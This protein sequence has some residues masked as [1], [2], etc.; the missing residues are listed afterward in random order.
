MKKYIRVPAAFAMLIAIGT[1]L[2]VSGYAQPLGAGSK[3]G[4][5]SWRRVG[6]G[7]G[8]AMFY[9]AV[10]PHNPN[11]AFVSC[12]MGG[13]YATY[14]GG[15]SWRMFNLRSPVHYYVFDP[16]DS[17]VVYANSVALFKSNDRGLSWSVLYPSPA[18]IKAIVSRGDHAE[19]EVVTRDSSRRNV[20]AMAV[21]P[22]DSRKLYAAISIDRSVAFY[23]SENSGS[24]WVREHDLSDGAMDIFVVPS[25]PG[26]NRTILVTGHNSITTKEDG[27]WTVNKGPKGVES[28]TR[29]SGGFDARQNKFIIYAISG[30]SYFNPGGDSSGIFFS[31]DGGQNWE[32]RKGG[33]RKL[34]SAGE[35]EWRTV[36][37]S[38]LHPAIVYVSYNGLRVGG[39]TS[40]IGVAV[41]RDFGQSWTLAWQDRLAPKNNLVSPNMKT[42]WIDDRFGP[43]W[44]ENPFSIGVAPGDPN[45]CYATDFGRTIKTTN[46]GNTWEQVYTTRKTGGGWM[47]TGLEVT[48]GYS[49]VFDPF[50]QQK[51]YICNTDIG[52]M[53]SEDGGESWS[54]T[55]HKNGIPRAWE[56][57]TYWLEFD[58][59]VKGRAWAAMSG[60]HDLPRPKMFRKNGTGAYKGG[61][62]ITDD[63][64]ASWKA[65]SSDIGEAA[66]THILI[67]PN[68]QPTSRTLYATAFGKGVYKSTDG[69]KT[70]APKNKG[71]RGQEPFAWRIIRR[72]TDGVLFLVVSRRSENGNIGNDGDGAVYRSDDGA[73]TWV[74]VKLPQGTNGPTCLF[75]DPGNRKRIILSAWG[76]AAPGRFTADQGGGIFTSDDDG[77]TWKQVLKQDQHIHD[78]TYDDR[79]K[80]YYA[81]GFNAS[82]YRSE[83][84]GNSWKRIKGY[85]FK[86]GKRVD[87]DPR[88]PS[89]IFVTTFGGGTWY[90]PAKGDEQAVEDIVGPALRY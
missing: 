24:S 41:S 87:P 69:G 71:L 22:A 38:A 18:D 47:S 79:V 51:L 49:V 77:K 12:D 73:D 34:G 9:P 81:C 50:D 20:L 64:G 42:G 54:S 13:A 3:D 90:G 28:V 30:K 23:R 35:P 55:T 33:L 37:T 58:P 85:N 7:G 66:I 21:D 61:V 17:N 63:G 25:S 48:T 6:Y 53:K 67:D 89:M 4:G 68:S 46:G 56:N 8:G 43:G 76:R 78:I 27:R 57:S 29:Y 11:D 36:A 70:W 10:S 45:V 83:D 16:V 31:A 15:A 26:A 75:A 82:A 40:C 39:D 32:N 14:D 19:E 72:Q 80:T 86:W 1:L 74:P 88:D 65:V 44:G 59:A 84:G 60:T 52:L 5:H 2:L 62:L